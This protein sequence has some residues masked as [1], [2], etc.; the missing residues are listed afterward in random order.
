M[1]DQLVA[2]GTLNSLKTLAPPVFTRGLQKSI[3]FFSPPIEIASVSLVNF[4][5]G[6]KEKN[7]KE[8]GGG[9]PIDAGIA[10]VHPI[11]QTQINKQKD[12]G[13]NRKGLGLGP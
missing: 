8:N 2:S 1:K 3:N 7:V 6:P 5:L 9:K 10:C 13:A 11:I 12:K 4:P